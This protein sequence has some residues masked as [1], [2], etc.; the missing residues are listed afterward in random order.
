M[1]RSAYRKLILGSVIIGL[2]GWYGVTNFLI[3]ASPPK[4]T[5]AVAPSSEYRAPAEVESSTTNT[6]DQRLL[7]EQHDLAAAAWPP[8]PFRR[9]ETNENTSTQVDDDLADDDKTTFVLNAII[10]G[11]VPLAM[12]NGRVIVVGDQLADGSTVAAIDTYS[13]ELSG[14]MGPWT[15][16]L[17][18]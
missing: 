3:G 4:A 12:I 14:P 5:A 9:V 18:E 16:T 10:S 17:S 2:A 1:N 7:R 13:V 11:S 6:V 8:D 15:L